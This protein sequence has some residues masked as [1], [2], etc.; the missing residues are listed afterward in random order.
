MLGTMRD[1]KKKKNPS[2]TLMP[3]LQD[4]AVTGD[5]HVTN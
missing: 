2:K 1:K 4:A 3:A 5:K